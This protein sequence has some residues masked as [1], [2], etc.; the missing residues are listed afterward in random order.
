MFNSSVVPI[1][2]LEIGLVVLFN[3]EEVKEARFRIMFVYIYIYHLQRNNTHEPGTA[4]HPSVLLRVQAIHL[5]VLLRRRALRKDA[6][7]EGTA[8]VGF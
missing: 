6:G 4:S 8:T 3:A 1:S 7:R 5:E 2:R